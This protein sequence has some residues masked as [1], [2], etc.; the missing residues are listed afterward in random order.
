M[1]AFM[2]QSFWMDLHIESKVACLKTLS[3]PGFESTRLLCYFLALPKVR[4][5]DAG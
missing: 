2:S 3:G 4:D 1:T 5:L